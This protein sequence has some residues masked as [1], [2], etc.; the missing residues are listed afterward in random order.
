M[1]T[2]F[3]VGE[4]LMGTSRITVNGRHYDN[5]DE[6]PPDVRR[7]YEEA[8]RTIR[9]SPAD[10]KKSDDTQVITGQ[11]GGGD[12]SNVVIRRTITVNN[13][14]YKNVDEMPPEVRR[15]F[16]SGLQAQGMTGIAPS[17]PG[18][19]VTVDVGRPKVRAF[20]HFGGST[21]EPSVPIEA[22]DA[23]R[24]ARDF[25]WDLVFWVAVALVLWTFLGC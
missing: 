4:V 14:T 1:V 7:L 24:K 21:P 8:L 6:M 22:S 15:F 12:R 2:A 25:V 13:R 3:L 11:A 23:E 19:Q 9:P 16:E 17:A 20:V 10:G 5:P 18:P